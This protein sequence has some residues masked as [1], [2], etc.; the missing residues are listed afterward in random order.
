LN[1]V[2]AIAV[3][4]IAT[5]AAHAEQAQTSA[6]DGTYSGVEM[7][8][9]DMTTNTT[10]NIHAS[11]GCPQFPHPGALFIK[12]GQAHTLWGKDPTGMRGAVSPQGRIIM[13]DNYDSRIEG[14]IDISGKVTA[15]GGW[16]CQYNFVWQKR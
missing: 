6:L 1:R 14:I 3:T 10:P 11:H 2:L 15:K 13:R 12:Q 16:V 4:T 9:T 7:T 5:A 8:L